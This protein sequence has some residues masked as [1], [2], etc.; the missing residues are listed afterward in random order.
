MACRLAALLLAALLAVAPAK[1]LQPGVTSTYVRD[2]HPADPL[3]LDHKLLARSSSQPHAPEQVSIALS[4]GGGVVSIS[5]VC[6]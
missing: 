3:P 1:A 4:G 2:P 6:S 5:W